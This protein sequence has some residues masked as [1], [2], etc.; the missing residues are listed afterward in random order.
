MKSKLLIVFCLLPVCAVRAQDIREHC[1]QNATA[2][3]A[4]SYYW[5]PDREVRIHFQRGLFTT[6]ERKVLLT[7]IRN[8][9]IIA[10]E[11]NT[12]VKFT[13]AGE[14]D[15]TATCTSCL[16]ITRTEVNRKD[17]K[18]YAFFYPVELTADW[19]LISARIE[20][21][22]ATTQPRALQSFIAHELGHGMGLADCPTC[23]KKKTIMNSFPAINRDN[24]LIAPSE[25]DVKIVKQIYEHRRRHENNSTIGTADGTP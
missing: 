21:D 7:T 8:W 12:G 2:P 18:H 23:Q 20:L 14:L 17:P 25:C 6:E 19:L 1:I 13:Y 9:S 10:A 16:R 15:A 11:S 5:R 3:S 4:S 22:F 24:G